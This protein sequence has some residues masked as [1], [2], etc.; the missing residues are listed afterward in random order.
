MVRHR[1]GAGHEFY[2]SMLVPSRPV[3][4]FDALVSLGTVQSKDM[5]YTSV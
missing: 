2:E 3:D 4:A 1:L 5:V